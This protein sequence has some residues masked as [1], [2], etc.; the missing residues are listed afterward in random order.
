MMYSAKKRKKR[1]FIIECMFCERIMLSISWKE[2]DDDDDFQGD[3]D[4]ATVTGPRRHNST[5]T[6]VRGIDQIKQYIIMLLF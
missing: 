3:D 1:N 6:L 2:N 5:R 4:S